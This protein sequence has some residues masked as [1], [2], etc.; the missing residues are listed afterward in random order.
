MHRNYTAVIETTE[1][2]A[3][4][5]KCIEVGIDRAAV[6]VDAST[7]N[8]KN[9]DLYP[10][11][12]DEVVAR[13]LSERMEP[14]AA[15][16]VAGHVVRGTPWASY[17]TGRIRLASAAASYLTWLV[18]PANWTPGTAPAIAGRQPVAWCSPAGETIVDL[19]GGGRT[20]VKQ[21]AH[22]LARLGHFA[23]VRAIDLVAPTKSV[24]YPSGAHSLP[25]VESEW[26][27]GGAR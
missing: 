8:P 9:E 10:R 2:Q 1:E 25:L 12:L 20:Y 7:P 16:A 13:L 14:T 4:T 27:F 23:A 5:V 3:E 15:L 17:R 19:L 21:L 6:E 24:A 22:P 11:L 18:P 26:W